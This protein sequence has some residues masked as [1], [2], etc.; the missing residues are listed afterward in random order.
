MSYFGIGTV[1]TFLEGNSPMRLRREGSW[2]NRMEGR[3]CMMHNQRET[4]SEQYLPWGRC[5]VIEV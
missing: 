5:I 3:Q 2:R 1:G 4:V